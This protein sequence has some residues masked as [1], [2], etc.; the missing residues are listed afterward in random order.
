MRLFSARIP[1]EPSVQGAVDASLVHL[2]QAPLT[3]WD[4]AV[5]LTMPVP[6][7]HTNGELVPVKGTASTPQ[8]QLEATVDST[9][10]SWTATLKPTPVRLG[11]GAELMVSGQASPT[12]YSF[13][14]AGQASS[15]QLASVTHAL[16]QLADDT[17]LTQPKGST[18]ADP[19]HLVTLSCTRVLSG[20]QT[21]SAPVPVPRHPARRNVRLH[22]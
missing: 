5:T 17:G 22:R 14:L 11:P 15:A 10:D 16:P 3:D 7:R 1:P 20:G 2:A 13:T 12:G 4:G 8:Q 18:A 9:G 21:C 19:I 6:A